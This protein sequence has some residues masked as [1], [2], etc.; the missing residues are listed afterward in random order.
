[1][2]NTS[3]LAAFE[4]MWQHVVAA[5]GNKADIDSVPVVDDTMSVSGAAADAAAVGERFDSL[6]TVVA[7]DEN[8]DGNIEIRSYLPE[9]DYLQLDKSLTVEGA[10]AEGAATGIAIS[11]SSAPYNY[12]DNSDF[13]NPVNQR[14]NTSYTSASYCID[15]WVFTDNNPSFSI[16]EGVGIKVGGLFKEVYFSQ[17]LDLNGAVRTLAGK[18]VT[19]AA[20][21]DKGLLLKSMI[22]PTTAGEF[23]RTPVADDVQMTIGYSSSGQSYW[24]DIVV[25]KN[26]TLTLYWAALYEG[27]YT[28]ETL[29]EYKPKGYTHELLECQRYFIRLA[30]PN[31]PYSSIVGMGTASSTSNC[32]AICPLPVTMRITPTVSWARAE[33]LNSALG[34]FSS[35][36]AVS[37]Y[38]RSHNQI[39]L[40]IATSSSTALT[41]SALYYL[42]CRYNDGYVDLSADL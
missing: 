38:R 17:R 22:L 1:M 31:N 6:D 13:R 19:F 15:R 4:R 33:L 41:Q 8:S 14:G 39:T 9:Q 2:A 26:K 12:L 24:V 21:S 25:A 7:V 28:A 29:P 30:E 40:S 18:Y 32:F 23:S 34:N 42:V 3:I 37:V 36:S 16:T 11:K 35:I 10:A 20:M 5:L 27:E